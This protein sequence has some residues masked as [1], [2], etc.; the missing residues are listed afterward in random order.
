M[1]E[2]KQATAKEKGK[3]QKPTRLGKKTRIILIVGTFL[4]LFLAAL[5]ILYQ[6]ASTQAALN[7]ELSSLHHLVSTATTRKTDLEARISQAEKDIQAAKDSFSSV[8]HAADILTE[9]LTLA[10]ANYIEVASS[11]IAITEQKL[12]IGKNRIEYPIL[13]IQLSFRGEISSFQSF[14]R[15]LDA[16]FPVAEVR[17]VNINL[18][19]KQDE[20]DEVTITIGIYCLEE[21][22]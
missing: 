11:K 20:Q 15:G 6:Q 16:K 1:V 14:L 19:E 9:L 17:T 4:V 2:M 7:E 3:E 8:D 18:S 22:K 10:E 12:T 5:V 13:E 21:S